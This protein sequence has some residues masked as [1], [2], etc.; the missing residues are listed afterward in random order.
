MTGGVILFL[1]GLRMSFPAKDDGPEEFDTSKE[2]LLVPL[3][4]PLIAG[5]GVLGLVMLT[6]KRAQNIVGSL[7]ALLI[8]WAA[9]T[10]I[11][12]SSSVM[13]RIMGSRGMEACQ[14]LMGLALTGMAVQMFMSGFKTFM[15]S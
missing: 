14:R 6:A 11:L 10:I 3:A 2:P 5:P 9:C 8:A 12:L 4:I 15:R 13:A 1:I 7:E